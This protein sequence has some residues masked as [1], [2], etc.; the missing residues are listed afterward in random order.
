[1]AGGTRRPKPGGPRRAGR[2]RPATC[3]A[4]GDHGGTVAALEG[5]AC[6]DPVP[7]APPPSVATGASV[8]VLVGRDTSQ[9]Y[10]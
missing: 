1:M 9:T 6:K 10:L 5:A 3:G 7:R 4:R 8:L 2:P